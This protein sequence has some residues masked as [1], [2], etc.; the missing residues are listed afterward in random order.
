MPPIERWPTGGYFN[1]DTT[2]RASSAVSTCAMPM[3]SAPLSRAR[4][5]IEYPPFGPR[6]I[7]AMPASSAATHICAQASNDMTPCSMSRNSQSNPATAIALPISTLRVRRTPTPSDNWP[8]SN[9]S[10]ATLRTLMAVPLFQFGDGD[11]NDAVQRREVHRMIGFIAH[12]NGQTMPPQN[13]DALVGRARSPGGV[14]RQVGKQPVAVGAEARGIAGAGMCRGQRI[15]APA[16]R[17]QPLAIPH[18]VLQIQHA[19]LGI[20]AQRG[21]ARAGPDQV[22]GDVGGMLV[23]RHAQPAGQQAVDRLVVRQSVALDLVADDRA[24][25]VQ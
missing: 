3:P 20:V 6:A 2:S 15:V 24:Q 12:R 13:E 7:G 11:G 25:H 5:A 14:D 4:V 16:L 9:F 22:A 23:T 19:E 17:Q 8:C 10:R 18:A 1:L 21:V